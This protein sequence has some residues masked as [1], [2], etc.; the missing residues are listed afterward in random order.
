MGTTTSKQATINDRER[1]RQTE[2]ACSVCDWLGQK[3]A[4]SKELTLYNLDLSPFARIVRFSLAE[5]GILKTVTIRNVNV[6]GGEHLEPWFASLSPAM[7]V[8]V[9]SIGDKGGGKP[10]EV[11]CDSRDIIDYLENK[12]GSG[13]PLVGGEEKEET[14]AFVDECYALKLS[15]LY[16]GMFRTEMKPVFDMFRDMAA[17]TLDKLDAKAKE[18][19]NL[20][21][22]YEKKKET[23][24][25]VLA[26]VYDRP[27]SYD[28]AKQKQGELLDFAE[29]QLGNNS[30]ES[31]WLFSSYSIADF[32]L[33][34]ILS[35]LVM[36]GLLKVEDTSRPKLAEYYK[37]VK[38]RPSYKQANVTD[39][40]PVMMKVMLLPMMLIHKVKSLFSKQSS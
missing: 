5:K 22:A 14:W 27:E 38:K 8:P 12:L 26:N 4:E 3:M 10:D 36:F 24:K 2:S 29:S 31:P 13:T 32:V 28:E 11:L 15:P 25:E 35:N 39:A 18:N 21:E 19:P 37:H 9:L 34:C 30:S 17:K 23:N 40:L 7:T 33:T 16:L 1:D 20:Q 6:R